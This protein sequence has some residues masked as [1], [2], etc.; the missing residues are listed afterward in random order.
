VFC[1]LQNL[2]LVIVLQIITKELLVILVE[3]REVV[4]PPLVVQPNMRDEVNLIAWRIGGVRRGEAKDTATNW[5][6]GA[7]LRYGRNTAAT[8]RV[9]R[10]YPS[11]R[12]PTCTTTSV[13]PVLSAASIRL[14]S[15]SGNVLVSL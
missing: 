10:S 9:G 4:P 7:R 11:A 12:I 5:I 6:Y 14:R 13:R 2:F 3:D 15:C 1:T 8:E